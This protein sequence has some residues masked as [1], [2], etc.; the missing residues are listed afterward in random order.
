MNTIPEYRRRGYAGELIQRAIDDA[1]AQGRAGPV[2]T[3]KDRLV[4]YCAK[5]GRFFV[6]MIRHNKKIFRY[7]PTILFS[8]V[9]Y[10]LCLLKK[11]KQ[12]PH[13]I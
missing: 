5:F 12:V 9:G 3:C 11:E 13:G 8:L 6:F 1:R 2:L 7:V 10:K 4:D